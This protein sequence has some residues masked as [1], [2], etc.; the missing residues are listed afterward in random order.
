[1]GPRSARHPHARRRAR[2]VPA[3]AQRGTF[4]R[5]CLG[6]HVHLSSWR[7]ARKINGIPFGIRN[8][9]LKTLAVTGCA[10]ASEAAWSMSGA[11][12]EPVCRHAVEGVSQDGIATACEV[13]ANLVLAARL[14]SELEQRETRTARACHVKHAHAGA[15]RLAHA[16]VHAHATADHGGHGAR[17]AS[18]THQALGHLAAHDG[19]GSAS[20]C[21]HGRQ[22]ARPAWAARPCPGKRAQGRWCRRPG[23]ARPGAGRPPRRGPRARGGPARRP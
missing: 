5:R 15:A 16:S 6:S 12:P 21:R 14:E 10:S 7:L 17:A 1:M 8:G 23:A 20:R 18:I 22:R 4:A 19:P 3:P 13:H 11:R 9:K 2:L